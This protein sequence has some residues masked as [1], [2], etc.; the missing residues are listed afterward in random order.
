MA[1]ILTSNFT[2]LTEYMPHAAPWNDDDLGWL[3]M[4]LPVLPWDELGLLEHD[5]AL[6]VE[7]WI[8]TENELIIV[9]DLRLRLGLYPLSDDESQ[10]LHHHV[11]QMRLNSRRPCMSYAGACMQFQ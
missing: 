8:W 7:C 5:V 11:W 2:S 3:C 10:F 9:D 1:T 6:S 4:T